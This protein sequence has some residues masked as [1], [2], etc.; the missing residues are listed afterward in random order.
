[1]MGCRVCLE[2]YNEAFMAQAER[3]R[4]LISGHTNLPL[5]IARIDKADVH[6]FA[7]PDLPGPW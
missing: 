1:M 4:D 7:I 5:K 2:K 3:P 6:I